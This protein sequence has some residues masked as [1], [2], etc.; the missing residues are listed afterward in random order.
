M[1]TIAV[2]MST[3]NGQKY[4]M[5][6][7]ESIIGQKNVRIKLFIRDDGSTDGTKEVLEKVLR[8][9]DNVIVWFGDNIGWRQSFAQ[10]ILD[11]GDFDY[12]AFADQD[13][14]WMEDKLVCAINAIRSHDNTPCVYRGRSIISDGN[15]NPSDAIF[16]KGPVISPTRALFQNYCQG[17]TMVFNR[18]L[19][20]LYVKHP[21]PKSSH[22]VWLPLIALHT[23]IIVDDSQPHMLYRVH[24]SNASAGKSF[25]QT[26]RKRIKVV[27]KQSDSLYHYNYGKVLYN[28]FKGLLNEES[29]KICE[30]MAEYDTSLRMKMKLLF[31]PEVRGNTFLRTLLVKYFI[32][33]NSYRSDI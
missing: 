33:T 8:E 17:C 23:G 7:I 24:A 11:A 4:I 31:N 16:P 12:Y 21:I 14:Y 2:L 6:Q 5:K 18:C 9:H 28:D 25:M 27:K 30:Q 29:L 22:D 32:I 13:D 20:D 3:Y 26:L 10:L 19:R 15:L 1:D